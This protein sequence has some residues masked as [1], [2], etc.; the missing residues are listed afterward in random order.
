MGH[1]RLPS[2]KMGHP[3]PFFVYYRSFQTNPRPFEHE[4]S[5]VT[6]KPGLP[7]RL[8]FAYFCSFQ[9]RVIHLLHFVHTNKTGLPWLWDLARGIEFESQF[10]ILHW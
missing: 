10:Q 8:P 4:L 9:Q 2:L 6:T 5:P 7:P 3:R 1:S